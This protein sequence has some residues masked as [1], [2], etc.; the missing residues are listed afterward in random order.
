MILLWIAIIVLSFYLLAQLTDRYFVPA[1]EVIG[2]RLGMNREMSGAT[3]MA[4]GSSA[5]ELAIA[6]IAL[7]FLSGEAASMGAG[8]IIGSALFNILVI[9]GASALVRPAVLAWQ[10]IVRDNLFYFLSIL[11]LLIS[12]WDGQIV[13][14]EAVVFVLGYVAYLYAVMNWRLW[15]PYVEE[16]PDEPVA[17]ENP[18]QPGSIWHEK[19]TMPFDRALALFYAPRLGAGYDFAMSIVLIGGLSFALVE[20]AV[21][22]AE[23]LR[24]HPAIIAL[25][26]LAFGTSVPD[27]V[28]SLVVA[29]RGY[30]GMA[31]SNA[32]GSNIINI[33]VG[34][35]LPWLL[36]IL[37]TSQEAIPVDN[38]NLFSSIALLLF[39]I[40]ATLGIY[41]F[42][43]W[44]LGRRGGWLLIGAYVGYL[45]FALGT[46]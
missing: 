33:M 8:T 14:Y 32:V 3:L 22:V 27:L 37:F 42:S 29:R 36:L 43:G 39:T 26:V 25:T 18:D 17:K 13:L 23:I 2:D 44:K 40:L 12:F 16:I 11:W 41:H 4:A 10:P 5:P 15:F 30:G 7:F 38:E 31:V 21:S 20:S 35:G 34:L 46:L 1:L 19:L 24:V 45:V 9:I 28:S 6:L